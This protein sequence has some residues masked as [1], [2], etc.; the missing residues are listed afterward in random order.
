MQAEIQL[1][2][3]CHLPYLGITN[4]FISTYTL[5]FFGAFFTGLYLARK[6]LR[7][8]KL[9][10]KE[11]ENVFSLSLVGT[12]IGA[13]LGFLFE[14]RREV[15]IE[16]TLT[17][18]EVIFSAGG[19]VFYGGLFFSMILLI[20]YFT[21]KKKDILLYA[22]AFVPALAVGYG[23]GRLG[24]MIS[25]DGCYGHMAPFK[26]PPLSL[27][28]G[29]NTLIPTASVV[30][31]NTPFV[32]SMASFLFFVLL[33]S[34]YIPYSKFRGGSLFAFLVWNGL[35]RFIVE[36]VRLNEAV[37]PILEPPMLHTEAGTF[38]LN[39]SNAVRYGPGPAYF[40]ENFYWYGITAGQL[41]AI[42]AMCIGLI[43]LMRI[44]KPES[45]FRIS[46]KE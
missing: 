43:G 18:Q 21:W 46:K 23:I 40:L 42:I 19:L 33:L 26:A 29:N 2:V 30:V 5:F 7:Q 38:L 31:W 35:V 20:I 15:F 3:S 27:V 44:R 8:R 11:A 22:D 28:F 12:F 25:G 10:I 34:N 9:D 32:E 17:W 37:I 14:M 24:C 6:E 13:K 39:Y 45:N 41:G 1:P 36:F 4:G 16:H